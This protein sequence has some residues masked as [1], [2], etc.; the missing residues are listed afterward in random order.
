MKEFA[1]QSLEK[2]INR[3]L[4]LDPEAKAQLAELASNV[5]A[6][7]ITDWNIKFVME[8]TDEGVKLHADEPE[9][10]HATISGPLFGILQTACSGG[11]SSVMRQAGLHMQGDIQLAEKLRH[12]LSGLDIDWEEP[13]ARYLGPTIAGS[14]STGAKR[15]RSMLKDML[16]SG[17][18]Q[19]ATF[20]KADSGL[21]PAQDEVTQFNRAVT[22]LRHDVDRLEAR[23]NK[24]LNSRPQ[25]RN[26]VDPADKPR[27]VDGKG[28]QS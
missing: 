9:E 26:P 4:A 23:M 10:I 2:V 20:L 18:N 16:E 8:L 21:L 17:T 15:A 1:C 5:I 13:L 22:V 27:D 12:V 3:A 6:L 24:L 25:S 28:A 14:I 11:K 19:L 7:D